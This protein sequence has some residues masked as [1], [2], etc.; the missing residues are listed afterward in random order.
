MITFKRAYPTVISMGIFEA[1][2]FLMTLFRLCAPSQALAHGDEHAHATS[3]IPS[4]SDPVPSVLA[5]MPLNVSSSMP[6]SYFAYPAMSTFMLAHI[7]LMT[8]AWFFILPIGTA[9]AKSC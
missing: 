2:V 8:I 6:A 9:S 5:S 7:T 1:T 4:M 3:S